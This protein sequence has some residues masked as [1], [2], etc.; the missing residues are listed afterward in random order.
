[1]NMTI[2][3]CFLQHKRMKIARMKRHKTASKEDGVYRKHAVK[4]ARNK[5]SP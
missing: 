5:G 2:E 1:M 4:G 3:N